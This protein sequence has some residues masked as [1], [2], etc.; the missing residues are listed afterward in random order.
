[1]K[2]KSLFFMIVI[3]IVFICSLS[4]Q[5]AY[6]NFAEALQKSLYFY[7][8]EKCG[9]SDTNRLEWRG[10]CHMED[11]EIPIAPENTNLNASFISANKSILDPDGDGYMN[12]IGGYHDAG[13]H[14]QFGLPQGYSAS[15]LGWGLY[16]FTNAFVD[17]DNY[18]HM[19]EILKY[20]TDFFLRCTFKDSSG[21]VVAY[22]YQ[23]GDG[24]VD[25]AYWGP[26]E[27]QDPEGLKTIG[28]SG[29]TY[30]RP[31]WFA[32]PDIPGSDVCAQA[33]ASLTAMY[34]NYRDIDATYANTCLDTAKAL[35]DF[36][37]K[38]RGCADSGGYYG[39]AYDY[40][41]LSWAAVWLYEATGDM[42][43]IDDIMQQDSGGNYTGYMQ[44][45]IG[46]QGDTWV[47]I[48]VHCWDVVWSGVFVKLSILFP[49]NEDYDYWARWN[50]EYWSGGEV[51]HE[52]PGDGTY[53]DY[54]PGGFGVINTWGSARYNT[55]A[56][57]CALIYGKHHNRTDFADWAKGQMTYI[58]GDNPIDRSY[59]VGYGNNP[60]QHP[61]HRAAHGSFTNSM[62][63]PPEHRHTLWGALASGPDGD[64]YH[65]DSV[66]EYSYNEVAVD[67][68]AGFVGALA[69]LYEYFGRVAGHKPEADFPPP[70]PDDVEQFWMEARIEQENDER[71]QVTVKVNAIPI[72][73]PEPITGIACRYFFDISE[74]VAVD[75]TI[76][77]ITMQIYYD[78]QASRYGGNVAGSGPFE[79]DAANN[80]YYYEFEWN[81]GVIGVRE[82]QFGL[83]SGIASDNKAHWDPTNDFSRQGLTSDYA[84]SEYIPLYHDGVLVSGQEPGGGS[85]TTTAPTATPVTTPEPTTAGTPTP[86][87]LMGDVNSNGEVDIVDALLVAQHYV[88]LAPASFNEAAADV[89]RDGS[90]DIV[91]ALRI[92]QC[93]VGLVSCD[94]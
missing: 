87:V 1:M 93:Y 86:G 29:V 9:F 11:A 91:D 36:G 89:T 7:D 72:H 84:E 39:S 67:Y 2:Q 81:G 78:E 52:D 4:A 76:S 61:H 66:K 48:W 20:F 68:N 5:S 14:V 54:T 88:G 51:P 34:F 25:H 73:L 55:A 41:E 49:D 62:D 80:I 43:Y 57:L 35:Y 71:T 85:G 23:T 15:T 38:Y 32:Y 90:I 26:P 46:T 42:S 19:L 10:P 63:D 37:V 28:Q 30:P 64:D 8:A 69:G 65:I 17:T 70:E 31:G 50:L 60:A 44:R 6:V 74:Q 3:F 92:A 53:M 16:E 45:L 47:N 13:D 33:S 40:D 12:L 58:M 83:F 21:N 94:F 79:W 56:Q 59:I 82:L 27:L 22:C 18:D 75:Q 77:D 24:S